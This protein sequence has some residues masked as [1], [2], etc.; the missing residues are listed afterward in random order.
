MFLGNTS[1]FCSRFLSTTA[2]VVA[3]QCVLLEQQVHHK[4]DVRFPVPWNYSAKETSSQ[5][6]P[7]K[8]RLS[9]PVKNTHFLS[10]SFFSSLEKRSFQCRG[11]FHNNMCEYSLRAVFFPHVTEQE[12]L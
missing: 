3:C 4:T 1:L 8:M 2:V 5:L 7:M 6:C 11:V 10:A 9:R 12:C